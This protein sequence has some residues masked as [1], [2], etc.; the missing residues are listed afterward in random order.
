KVETCVKRKRGGLYSGPLLR[1]IES[2]PERIPPKCVHFGSC[3]GCSWQHIPYSQQLAIKQSF[4]HTYYPHHRDKT[5]SLLASPD[6]WGYRN[7][8]EFSFSQDKKGIRYLGLMIGGSRG[9]V[10]HLTECHLV[11]P[12][13]VE[14]VAKVRAWWEQTALR[15]FHPHS[16]RGTLRT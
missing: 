10:F 16:N 14:V 2:A 1:L 4:I 5:L 12:W 8:M 13:F 6:I 3:G 9:K 11:S 15:A 7:K